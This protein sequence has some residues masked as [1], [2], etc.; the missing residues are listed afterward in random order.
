MGNRSL[1]LTH[2][3]S[4]ATLESHGQLKGIHGTTTNTS[5]PERWISWEFLR[6]RMAN[7]SNYI[8]SYINTE[9]TIHSTDT[10][11]LRDEKC[12]EVV[13]YNYDGNGQPYSSAHHTSSNLRRSST[14]SKS[15]TLNINPNFINIRATTFSS[16][17]FPTLLSAIIHPKTHLLQY[18]ITSAG[19]VFSIVRTLLEHSS[20]KRTKR[21][22]GVSTG[23]NVILNR[24]TKRREARHMVGLLKYLIILSFGWILGRGSISRKRITQ[25]SISDNG[26]SGLKSDGDEGSSFS[27]SK[28]D[29]CN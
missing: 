20:T 28:D 11:R 29:I 16:F 21:L 12:P 27:I 18:M 7:L 22:R 19:V 26:S 15:H 3:F 8:E 2:G 24:S 13:D 9:A 17:S 10:G 25:T 5:K 1:D 14:C 4:N 23:I 6:S